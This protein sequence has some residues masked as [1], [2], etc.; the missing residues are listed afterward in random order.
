M[1][2]Q[3]RKPAKCE[4]SRFTNSTLFGDLASGDLEQNEITTEPFTLRKWK[5]AFSLAHG[6]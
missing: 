6:P 5:A 4:L 3:F 2:V 1:D